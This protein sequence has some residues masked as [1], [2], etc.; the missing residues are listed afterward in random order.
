MEMLNYLRK[1]PNPTNGFKLMEEWQDIGDADMYQ[2]VQ[3]GSVKVKSYLK[4][5]KSAAELLAFLRYDYKKILIR[6]RYLYI[7]RIFDKQKR[8]V[9]GSDLDHGY[10]EPILL[11][12]PNLE[13]IGRLNFPDLYNME[14]N[15]QILHRYL[16]RYLSKW[17]MVIKNM[18]ANL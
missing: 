7:D 9:S 17:A 15:S 1:R 4:D 18:L 8:R 6:T 10:F 11:C 5:I 12:F 3:R 16:R 14:R 2:Q 13:F